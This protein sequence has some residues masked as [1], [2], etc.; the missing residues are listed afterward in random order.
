[1]GKPF[2]RALAAA[3]GQPDPEG[4]SVTNTKGEIQPDKDLTDHEN[5]PLHEDI[6][7]YFEREVL[8][9]VPD[10]WIDEKFTDDSKLGDGEVGKV[11]YEINFNRYFYKYEPPRPLEEID[12][13]L[14]QV[15]ADIA[16]LLAEVTE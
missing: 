7:A 15:E 10:A 8:P 5:V 9:H 6:Q 4:E 11:G 2:A 3:F 14:K 16:A 12:A 13:E 1:M